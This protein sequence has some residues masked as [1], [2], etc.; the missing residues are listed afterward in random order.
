MGRRRIAIGALDRMSS[1]VRVGKKGKG[2]KSAKVR[3]EGSKWSKW[4]TEALRLGKELQ[5]ARAELQRL[6]GEKPRLR[7][8]ATLQNFSMQDG[9]TKEYIMSQFVTANKD[10]VDV[11]DSEREAEEAALA[12]SDTRE[13]S[14]P[15]ASIS[16]HDDLRQ[17]VSAVVPSVHLP[18]GVTDEQLERILSVWKQMDAAAWDA[19]LIGLCSILANPMTCIVGW[20]LSKYNAPKIL[21]VKREKIVRLLLALEDGY[22]PNNP[23]HN[24]T[25]AADVAGMIAAVVGNEDAAGG[26]VFNCGTDK[27][28]SYDDLCL[29]AA[30]ALGKPEALVVAPSSADASR[31]KAPAAA[32]I[33]D[34]AASC[35]SHAAASASDCGRKMDQE[36]QPT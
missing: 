16:A 28:C 17:K 35:F 19:D 27:M 4:E 6:R 15:G 14:S 29:T 11:D 9:Q 25:H 23:Y 20:V 13:G 2:E 36:N 8:V 24:G 31:R 12:R 34:A 33:S 10:T 5:E 1:L 26:E 30:K 22:R 32:A 18:D 21:K 3:P 7:S